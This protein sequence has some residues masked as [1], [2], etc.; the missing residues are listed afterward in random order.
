MSL[1]TFAA[2]VVTAIAALG[3][4]P[5]A[6]GSVTIPRIPKLPKVPKID[7]YPVT[8][9]A[10][11]YVDF[12]WTWD[13]QQAC[14]PGYAK[15][16]SE[17]LSFELGKPRRA[18]VNIIGGAV[19][20]PF[21]IG[22]EAK[23]KASV[24]GFQT[25]NYCPPT[26]PEPEPPEPDCRTLKGK[27]GVL[28]TPQV[29]DQG[30]VDLAPLGRGV[31]VSFIRKGGASQTQSCL[32]NRPTLRA[33]NEK[34]GANVG[35][36]PLPGGELMVPLGANAPRF[37]SLKPGQRLS[38]TITIGGGCDTIKVQTAIASRLSESI[39]RCTIAG[40]IVVVIK[41]K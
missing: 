36:L 23:H 14:I 34:Q 39:K 2:V 16:V 3:A 9:D 30:D 31:M 40:K 15:T 28:L 6:A 12:N 38:R 17:E 33:A 20:M 37:L 13:D 1:R 24:G 27:L 8:I 10:A 19:T 25:T 26:R 35:T 5:S 29:E 41:R 21:A 7:S 32:E 4:L 11:G 22:G 18:V